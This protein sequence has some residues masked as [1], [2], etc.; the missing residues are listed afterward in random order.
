MRPLLSFD[1]W[2]KGN[3]WADALNTPFPINLV[4][5]FYFK[6]SCYK[7]EIALDFQGSLYRN[8]WYGIDLIWNQTCRRNN[9]N[10]F[11]WSFNIWI[12]K[13]KRLAMILSAAEKYS[14]CS[15]DIFLN[16][17]RHRAKTLLLKRFLCK[18]PCHMD[19]SAILSR[20][21]FKKNP[22]APSRL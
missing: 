11:T 13:K 9:R 5:L 18:R 10:G 21:Q 7:M 12:K 14:W 2:K 15:T 8:L 17:S 1:L 16:L 3:S 22:H 6:P 4:P 20:T 19:K